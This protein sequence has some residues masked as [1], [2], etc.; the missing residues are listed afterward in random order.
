MPEINNRISNT[1]WVATETLAQVKGVIEKLQRKAQRHGLPEPELK[2]TDNTRIDLVSVYED[3]ELIDKEFPVKKTMIEVTGT[4]PRFSDYQF[5]AKIDHVT[6]ATTNIVLT[7]GKQFEQEILDSGVDFHSC[8]SGCDHCGVERQRNETFVVKNIK[9]GKMVQVGSTCVDDYVGSKTLPQLMAAFDI[10]S[11]MYDVDYF[12]DMNAGFARGAYYSSVDARLFLALAIEDTDN[13]GF[14]PSKS[15]YSTWVHV[16]KC[17]FDISKVA[18]FSG[19]ERGVLKAANSGLNHPSLEKADK[20]IEWLMSKQAVI[21]TGKFNPLDQHGKWAAMVASVPNSYNKE[22]NALKLAKNSV[23]EPFG[24]EKSRGRLKLAVLK[25]KESDEYDMYASTKVSL[26]DDAG[27]KFNWKAAGLGVDLKVGETYL[28]TGTI[29]SHSEFNGIHYTHLSRCNDFEKVSPDTPEPK[30]T[31]KIKPANKPKI[32]V[33]D[34]AITQRLVAES[35]EHELILHRSW[36]ERMGSYNVDTFLSLSQDANIDAIKEQLLLDV[37]NV[38]SI[39]LLAKMESG[40]DEVMK[41]VLALAQAKLES[42]K[43]ESVITAQIK[44]DIDVP[45]FTTTHKK[46]HY[47]ISDVFLPLT[48]IEQNAIGG[49]QKADVAP[50]TKVTQIEHTSKKALVLTSQEL[51]KVEGHFYS[52]TRLLD[53]I[54][55]KGFDRIV[56]DTGYQRTMMLPAKKIMEAGLPSGV[57][58]LNRVMNPLPEKIEQAMGK[59]AIL[60]T[61]DANV[62]INKTAVEMLV[63][64]AKGDNQGYILMPDIHGFGIDINDSLPS[65]LAN[66]S[67]AG[68]EGLETINIAGVYPDMVQTLRDA[69]ADIRHIHVDTGNPNIS[70][71]FDTLSKNA[72]LNIKL[73]DGVKLSD[74]IVNYM[75]HINAFVSSYPK[76]VPE[77]KLTSEHAKKMVF[78][79]EALMDMNVSPIRNWGGQRVNRITEDLLNDVARSIEGKTPQEAATALFGFSEDAKEYCV[80]FAK[81]NLNSNVFFDNVTST[82]KIEEIKTEP[83]QQNRFNF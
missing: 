29:K 76:A 81:N 9:S 3:G 14:R 69:G 13:V 49:I 78:E 42:F 35:L 17:L 33:D 54:K 65:I 73:E 39:H 52:R 50:G 41:E 60:F 75:D 66:L 46:E 12:D 7:P 83:K 64:H 82:R 79:C 27:R 34:S 25:I 22:M 5:L 55:E 37:R 77:V 2:I 23:N 38:G 40:E 53:K 62:D 32:S 56:V 67:R 57:R 61:A 21:E 1:H 18:D 31:D 71:F 68:E 48:I 72:D 10:N 47:A 36:K 63:A 44:E 80:N 8:G 51:D 28:M 4:F 30:F 20:V 19:D 58:V 70:P 43:Y 16:N 6:S 59:K 74:S 45:A 15:D 11:I 24:V 26:V